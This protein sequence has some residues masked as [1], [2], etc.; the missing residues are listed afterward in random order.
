MNGY[1][2][3]VLE[4]YRNGDDDLQA[5]LMLG[6]DSD[7]VKLVEMQES[8]PAPLLYIIQDDL[9]RRYQGY[10]AKHKRVHDAANKLAAAV[11]QTQWEGKK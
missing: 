3:S 5:Y 8:L 7:M 11:G 1:L 4:K 6:E 10:A 2:K 9:R